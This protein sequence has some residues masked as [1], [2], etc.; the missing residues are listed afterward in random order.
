MSWRTFELE[1]ATE[2]QK[3]ERMTQFLLHS[4]GKATILQPP[5]SSYVTPLCTYSVEGDETVFRAIITGDHDR[6]FFGLEDGD[7]VARFT[8]IDED[9]LVF[10]SSEVV[11]FAEPDGR[12]VA[13]P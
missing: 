3:A 13:V 8:I 4:D 10:R 12:Y 11:L 9:T 7:V 6:G 5:I 1:N 2:R